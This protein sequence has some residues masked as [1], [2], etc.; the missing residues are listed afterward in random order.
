MISNELAAEMIEH[1]VAGMPN[2]AC[3]IL[4][5]NGAQVVKVFRMSN[6]S[7]SP[8]RYSLDPAEQFA[9][10]RKLEERGWDLGGV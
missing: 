10:Y 1:C 5:S 8:M 4:G 3:G 6:S 2:E 9:V 7:S